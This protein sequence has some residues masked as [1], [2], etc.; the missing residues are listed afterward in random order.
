MVF[1]SLL[2]MNNMYQ[3]S[4]AAFKKLFNRALD[5]R[6]NIPQIDQKLEKLSDTLIR[7]SYAEIAR[8]L[9]KADRLTYG[10]HFVHGV[11][12]H[13]FGRNEWE[14]FNGNSAASTEF[15]GRMPSWISADRK[16]IF[17]MFCNTF[18][19]LTNQM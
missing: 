16:E 12:S 3:F 6:P 18:G 10:L 5:T 13:L 17:G 15:N 1:G 11:Y 7:M 4:L 8:S 14:F 9:F 19:S 2:K